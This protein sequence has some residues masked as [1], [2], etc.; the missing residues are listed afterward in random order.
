MRRSLKWS[1]CIPANDRRVYPKEKHHF[2]LHTLYP[3]TWSTVPRN[4]PFSTQRNR[5]ATWILVFSLHIA[6]TVLM[7][8]TFFLSIFISICHLIDC[9]T[10]YT[11]LYISSTSQALNPCKV[12]E[13]QYKKVNKPCS[14]LQ[15]RGATH[16]SILNFQPG[17][18]IPFTSLNDAQPSTDCATL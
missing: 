10:S 15:C 11:S 12:I 18:K 6:V 5:F 3:N 4:S 14:S 2:F 1:Y 17:L 16:G 7:A 13:K 8:I 9:H